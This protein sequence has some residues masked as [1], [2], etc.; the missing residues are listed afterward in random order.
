[1]FE[2][3]FK[4]VQSGREYPPLAVQEAAFTNFHEGDTC[5]REDVARAKP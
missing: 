5:T 2:I 3:V 1:M 4:G